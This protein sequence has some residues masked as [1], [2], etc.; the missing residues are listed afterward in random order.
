MEKVKTI[1]EEQLV[2]IQEQQKQLRGLLTDIGFI[3]VQKH[4]L[5]HR[6]AELNQ[7]IESFKAELE[8]QYGAVNIDIETGV[9]TEIKKEE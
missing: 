9:Y 7:E 6:Q 1:T 5:L 4:G 2:K 8:K 3:E